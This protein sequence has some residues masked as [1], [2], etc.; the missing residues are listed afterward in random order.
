MSGEVQTS[1]EYIKHHLQ[2]LTFGK[3]ADGTWGLAHTHEQ[4][5]EM[6]FWALNIDSLGVGIML[7]AGLHPDVPFRCEESLFRCALRGAEFC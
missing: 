1:G 4:A 7:R 2:N 6:G 5:R 3:H